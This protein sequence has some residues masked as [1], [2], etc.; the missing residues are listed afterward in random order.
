MIV[1]YYYEVICQPWHRREQRWRFRCMDSFCLSPSVCH[2][3]IL[4]AT[5][6]P[7][8]TDRCFRRIT[9]GYFR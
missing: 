2:L 3:T 7:G 6:L 5:A 1:P 9:R 4:S 8:P